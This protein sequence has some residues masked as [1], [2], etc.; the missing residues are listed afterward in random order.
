[1][2]LGISLS[3]LVLADGR[4]TSLRQAGVLIALSVLS[5]PHCRPAPELAAVGSTNVGTRALAIRQRLVAGAGT[6]GTIPFLPG[7][8]DGLPVDTRFFG[9]VFGHSDDRGD[10]EALLRS[11]VAASFAPRAV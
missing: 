6:E 9:E 10:N 8:E 11:A 5:A 1:M 2:S 4:R 3:N 7:D